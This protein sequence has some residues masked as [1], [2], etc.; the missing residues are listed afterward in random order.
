VT[1]APA[2][3]WL[4][5]MRSTA[6][7]VAADVSLL[8]RRGRVAPALAQLARLPGLIRDE[9]A[10]AYEAG[11][12]DL[13]REIQGT[14]PKRSANTASSSRSGQAAR[15]KEPPRLAWLRQKVA[16]PSLRARAIVALRLDERAF[17][18]LLAGRVQ[19]SSGQWKRL[20]GEL[21]P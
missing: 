2:P 10:T 12:L 20:R 5:P 13:A 3:R 14:R 16:D 17:D 1:A 8:L 18:R 4:E 11:Q 19:L 9:V 6:A 7:E 15:R 21:G